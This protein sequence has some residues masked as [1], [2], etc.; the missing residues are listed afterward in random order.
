[1]TLLPNRMVPLVVAGA[2]TF[3]AP[4][5]AQ[6][7]AEVQV[8][9]ET[10]TLRVG[11]RQTLFATAYDGQGNIIPN[12]RFTFWS[13]DTLIAKVGK[14]GAV[15]GVTPGLAK[16]EARLQGRRAS[17]AILITGTGP[18]ADTS[19]TARG[20]AVLTLQP[21]SPTL[22]PGESVVIE[23]RVLREDGTPVTPG[24]VR[25]KSLQPEVA[26]VDSTGLVI[27]IAPGRT[28]IQATS[29]GGLMATAPVEVAMAALSLSKTR[30][31]LGPQ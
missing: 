11:E 30:V 15:V 19:A 5:P 1:M 10:M 27:A 24:R 13:S 28:I 9:P 14:G 18:A 7:A 17:M 22:L 12:A 31:T 6:T 21:A 3:A 25:W 26:A 29:T 23:P 16:V 20:G 2:F 4:L 8:T